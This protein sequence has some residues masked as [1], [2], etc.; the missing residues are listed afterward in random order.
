MADLCLQ[1]CTGCARVAPAEPLAKLV[2]AAKK[3]ART[4]GDTLQVVRASCLASCNA[5]HSGLIE[6]DHG[7]VRLRAMATAR[8]AALA[9]QH[10]AAAIADDEPPAELAALVLS[11]LRWADLD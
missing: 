3:Q 6:T 5:G 8:E 7:V 9:V 4:Q 11:R 2:T 10:G 1:L